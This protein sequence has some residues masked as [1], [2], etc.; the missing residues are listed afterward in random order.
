L[1]ALLDSAL[2]ANSATAI[3]LKGTPS[4]NNNSIEVT[5]ATEIDALGADDI[6]KVAMPLPFPGPSPV[7]FQLLGF[8]ETAA[9]GVVTTAEE[10]IADASNSMPVGTALALIE[11]GAK[12][13]S[14]IHAR[15]H[16]SQR[17]ALEILHR[18]NAEHLPE[19]FVYG[20]NPSDFVTREDFEGYMDVH[21]VSDPNIFSESQ[22]F[23]QFQFILQMYM[24]LAPIAPQV[25]QQSN[26]HALVKRG[27]EQIRFPNYQEI[28]PD[29]PSPKP[30]NPMDENIQMAL[31]NPVDVYDGQDHQAHIQTHL[32]FAQSPFLGLSPAMNPAFKV[33]ALNHVQK[34]LLKFYEE[35]MKQDA[36]M[37]L[38]G[39]T[40]VATQGQLG[41][42][43]K[44]S[45]ALASSSGAVLKA[46]NIAF[47]KIP[48]IM[49][50]A[51]Q[52]I[53][54]GGPKPPPDS[55]LIIAQGQQQLDQQKLSFEQRRHVDATQY[56]IQELGLKQAQLQ[57]DLGLQE[58]KLGAQQQD[59]LIDAQAG[60]EKNTQDNQTALEITR[61]KLEADKHAGNVKNGLGFNPDPNPGQM[62]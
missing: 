9:R 15:L 34:H 26:L 57:N 56:K 60:L 14:A 40:P 54:Q 8:L 5:Q 51:A 27:F 7:L 43:N 29:L 52:M 20:S 1:R 37:T 48:S 59:T 39:G 16:D 44:T 36:S 58:K 41:N 19:K 22:R 55:R 6:R 45:E 62:S 24:Q 21:P 46:M 13:F 11:Q 31:G 38:A 33:D 23:A 17:R 28:L 18:L 12:V 53:Q 47:E 10:K 2:I 61:M 35:L 25:I 30:L 32:D 42:D 50:Q 4:G 49:Q 3:K